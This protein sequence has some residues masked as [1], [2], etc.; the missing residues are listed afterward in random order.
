MSFCEE[1]LRNRKYYDYLLEECIQFI[2]D[3]CPDY[4][5]CISSLASHLAL[6]EHPELREEL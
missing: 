6:L 5:Y 3:D 1:I 2:W 4:A